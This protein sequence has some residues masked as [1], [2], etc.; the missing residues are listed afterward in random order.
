MKLVY[1]QITSLLLSI[2]QIQLG[3]TP[4]DCGIIRKQ[5]RTPFNRTLIIRIS[6]SL[7]VNFSKIVQNVICLEITGYRIKC[8]TVLWLLELQI[9]RRRKVQTQVHT[10]NSNSRTS[11]CQRSLFSKKNPIIRIF[12]KS[13]WLAVKIK[14][15][16]WSFTEYARCFLQCYRA[17]YV[18]KCILCNFIFIYIYIYI[19]MCVC[20]CVCVCMYMW[21]L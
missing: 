11:Y 8:S 13:G 12:C 18:H 5:S 20:V 10:V 19:Y 4:C 3:D 9:R 17:R 2:I 14:P 16:K 21:V 1:R 15:G 6:L 7:L